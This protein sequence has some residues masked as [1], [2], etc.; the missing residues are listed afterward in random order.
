MLKVMVFGTFDI[1]HPGHE[2]MLKEAKSLGNFLVVVI[3]RD[4]TVEKVKNH[5]P[6]LNENLRLK[7]L[8]R[9]NIADQVTLGTES[10]NKHLI[11]DEEKPDIIA[12]G[13]DQKFFIDE[14]EN[15]YGNILKIV[16]LSPYK[17]DVF[18]SSKLTN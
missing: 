15:K 16:R 8:K 3:A 12:L 10:E 2:H 11:I 9:L 6:R 1:L 17:E 4:K 18:K 14:L 13:Y 5:L 7:N